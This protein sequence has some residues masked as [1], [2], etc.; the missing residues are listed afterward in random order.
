[1]GKFRLN[2][3]SFI[4]FFFLMIRR[5]PRST[6]FPYTTL[7][8]SRRGRSFPSRRRRRRAARRRTRQSGTRSR[9][10]RRRS[11]TS[12]R[13]SG[14]PWELL[15]SLSS[16]RI[17]T[18]PTAVLDEFDGPR[19]G[20]VKGSSGRFPQRESKPLGR[21]GAVFPAGCD[22]RRGCRAG[23]LS[24]VAVHVRLV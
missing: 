6:L 9:L 23:E 12:E 2:D 7:F 18:L 20:P 16:G 21:D 24:E 14:T 22:E 8:R 13:Q 5:P 1:M 11:A 19:S 15:S 3:A 10:A 4:Y 17:G